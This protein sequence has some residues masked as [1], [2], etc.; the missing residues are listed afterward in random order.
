MTAQHHQHDNQ[1]DSQS[2][3]GEQ[4]DPIGPITLPTRSRVGARAM[5][6][7]G[8]V[9]MAAFGVA[10]MTEAAGGPWT[11]ISIAN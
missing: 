9:G 1:F 5:A 7:A 4:T 8:T 6:L 10:V 11:T 3:G 2:V